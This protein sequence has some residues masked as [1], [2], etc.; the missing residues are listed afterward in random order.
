MPKS[1]ENLPN[2][3]RWGQKPS[4]PGQVDPKMAQKLGKTATNRKGS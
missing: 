2:E 4:Q 3:Q 1:P